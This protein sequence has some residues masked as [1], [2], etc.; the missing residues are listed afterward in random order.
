VKLLGKRLLFVTGKGGV[1]KSTV[2]AALGVLAARRGLRTIVAEVAGRNDVPHALGHPRDVPLP[3]ET[4]AALGSGLFWISVDPQ[5]ALREYLL[6][7]LRV[8]ALAEALGQSRAFGYLAAAAPGLA[9]LL[10]VGKVW[11]L[12]QLERRAPGGRPFD[13]VVVDAPATGHGL[14]YLTAPRT[15]A[16]IARTG[17]IARQ[18]RTIHA[19]LA[20]PRQT[21]VVVVATPHELPV[22]EALLL[23][24][25]VRRQMGLELERTVMNALVPARF[26]ARDEGRLREALEGARAGGP[27][28]AEPR[29]LAPA[30]A[31]TRAALSQASQA[32]DQRRQ[33]ARL[34]RGVGRA[35][36]ALPFLYSAAVGPDQV[37][38]LADRLERAL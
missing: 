33:V 2:A 23:H 27:V 37:S 9:E 4:E 34:R 24:R 28:S 35:P 29:R 3:E 38:Q 15:F 30:E 25:E 16:E 36:A 31:G 1:G 11:E 19:T 18:A 8:R 17:P 20:D 7:Q 6:D 22:T 10:T 5:H 12:A 14:A 21:G 13:L 32:R 26:S